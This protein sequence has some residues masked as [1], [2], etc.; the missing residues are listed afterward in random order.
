MHKK[1]RLQLRLH[2]GMRWNAVVQV[3]GWPVNLAE[4][5]PAKNTPLCTSEKI[6]PHCREHQTSPSRHAVALSLKLV[7]DCAQHQER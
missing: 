7:N 5:M 2:Q 6:R 1:S 3:L 4:L